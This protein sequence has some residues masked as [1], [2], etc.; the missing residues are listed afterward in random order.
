MVLELKDKWMQDSAR[1]KWLFSHLNFTV[2]SD[3]GI[4][5]ESGCK[6]GATQVMC[7]IRCF[8]S[9]RRSSNSL[10]R[11]KQAAGKRELW[12]GSG[13]M[14]LGPCRLWIER[15]PL[16][17]WWTVGWF[18]GKS[19]GKVKRKYAF[20][21]NW[22][23]SFETAKWAIQKRI[24]TLGVKEQ[25]LLASGRERLGWFPW[26]SVA[27]AVLFPC[28]LEMLWKWVGM[29]V[30]LVSLPSDTWLAP[31]LFFCEGKSPSPPPLCL[32]FNLIGLPSH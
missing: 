32:H 21:R 31:G 11:N 8:S 25:S 2:E 23:Y 22:E 7:S 24:L 4:V 6:P 18:W 10:T 1:R 30:V 29:R 27:T 5:S 14:W 3:H 16:K 28:P 17:P 26:Q 9:T 13:C 15:Y 20:D 12:P 19:W